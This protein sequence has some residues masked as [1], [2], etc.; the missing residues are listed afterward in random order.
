PARP[1]LTPEDEQ[2]AQLPTGTWL[3]TGGLGGIGAA[4]AQR[5]AGPGRTLVL[6]SRRP[7]PDGPAWQ[8]IRPGAA[9]PAP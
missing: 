4:V 9:A 2:R 6:L 3:I 1:V 7:V 8:V 5:L